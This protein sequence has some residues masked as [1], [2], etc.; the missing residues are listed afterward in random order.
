MLAEI[1]ADRVR[2]AGGVG[3]HGVEVAAGRKRADR[4]RRKV[5][6][7]VSLGKAAHHYG[8]VGEARA[9]QPVAEQIAAENDADRQ[10]DGGY[11]E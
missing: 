4:P 9:L 2:I 11:D 8:A 5:R 7:H 10:N 6:G 1:G 3:L